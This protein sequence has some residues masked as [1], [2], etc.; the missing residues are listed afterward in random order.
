MSS[1]IDGA[2]YVEQ[3]SVTLAWN[4]LAGAEEYRVHLYGGPNLDLYS[5]WQI[6]TSWTIGAQ[7]A[8]YTY[9]WQVQARNSAGSGNWSTPRSFTIR[10]AA[11][12]ALSAQTISCT[13]ISLSWVDNSGNEEG[14]R[15]Y[16]NGVSAG[17]AGA[18]ATSYSDAGLSETT[19][20][21]YQVQAYRGNVESAPSNTVG[22]TTLSCTPHLPDLHPYAPIGYAASLVPSPVKGTHV[23]GPLY[24]GRPSFIDWHFT[25]S[26]DAAVSATFHVEVQVDDQQRLRQAYPLMAVNGVDGGDDLSATIQSVGWHTVTLVTDPDNAISES[27]E[28]NNISQQ[29]YYW[30]SVM[31]WWGEYFNNETLSGDPV[32]VRDDPE[33]NFDWRSN[34]PGPG[35]NADHF[36]ARWTRTVTLFGGTYRFTIFRDDGARLFVDGIKVFDAWTRGSEER[37]VDVKLDSGPHDIRFEMFEID[38]WAA[39]ILSWARIGGDHDLNLPLV[40]R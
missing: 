29:A 16:R 25:N 7:W 4:A 8:G 22:T 5:A 26:G 40:M 21:S 20:F 14:Y 9:Q 19:A 23:N 36:S 2:S 11:P 32:L 31:G 33:I 39:A 18:N 3:Q 10:P 1:P 24:A 30:Q 17:Q 12:S 13:Q 15:I 28:T 37:T 35:I 6:N 27:D 38:G 34:S